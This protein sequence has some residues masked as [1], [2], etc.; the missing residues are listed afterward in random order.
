[1]FNFEE[2]DLPEPLMDVSLIALV[3]IRSLAVL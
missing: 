2:R 1:M 3:S